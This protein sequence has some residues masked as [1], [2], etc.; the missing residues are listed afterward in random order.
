MLLKVRMLAARRHSR[1]L[2]RHVVH[3]EFPFLVA[4]L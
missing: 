4:A 2:C 3:S 1:L